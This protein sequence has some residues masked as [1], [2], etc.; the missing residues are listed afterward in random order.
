MC[1][2]GGAGAFSEMR[3][4]HRERERELSQLE[5]PFLLPHCGGLSCEKA[6]KEHHH[7]HLLLFCGGPSPSPAAVSFKVAFWPRF[8]RLNQMISLFCAREPN[9]VYF[10]HSSSSLALLESSL[11][12]A[13]LSLSLPLSA[14]LFAVASFADNARRKVQKIVNQANLEVAPEV[15]HPSE[16]QAMSE[17]SYES[18]HIYSGGYQNN[19]LRIVYGLPIS[20]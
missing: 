15:I 7:H 12:A 2:E 14:V 20:F 13:A 9:W 6:K 4:T 8:F 10:H 17:I 19:L 3:E 1:V 11:R 16:G 5:V 18:L